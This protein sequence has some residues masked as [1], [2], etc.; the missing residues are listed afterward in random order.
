L[1]LD[2]KDVEE[3]CNADPEIKQYVEKA[4]KRT[5]MCISD[6]MKAFKLQDVNA[7]RK[8]FEC[9]S[10]RYIATILHDCIRSKEHPNLQLTRSEIFISELLVYSA[11]EFIKSIFDDPELGVLF[12]VESKGRLV[13]YTW[14]RYLKR[15]T[16]ECV[17]RFLVNITDTIIKQEDFSNHEYISLPT[18]NDQV[19]N[20]LVQSAFVVI[21]SL[22]LQ[23]DVIQ[24]WLLED[25]DKLEQAR[26]KYQLVLGY[27]L[28]HVYYKNYII[29]N[30]EFHKDYL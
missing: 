17:S 8:V 13:T 14:L 22:K 3:L 6:L 28:T 9:Y 19:L 11:P 18:Y 15:E 16:I 25:D 2:E 5:E 24:N 30:T 20:S 4:V 23:K 1:L 7:L 29:E 26:I 27:S 10:V 12:N 21:P